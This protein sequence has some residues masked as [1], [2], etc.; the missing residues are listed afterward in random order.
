MYLHRALALI[1]MVM[2]GIFGSVIAMALFAFIA[3]DADSLRLWWWAG[4]A[5]GAVGTAWLLPRLR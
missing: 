1:L 4:F 3:H 5:A 2:G